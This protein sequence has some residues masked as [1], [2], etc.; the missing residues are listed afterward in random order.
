[1]SGLF[2]ASFFNGGSDWLLLAVLLPVFYMISC[3]LKAEK[4]DMLIISVSF[5]VAVSASMIKEKLVYDRIMAYSG[6]ECNFSGEI[7]S[8]D[9]YNNE[10]VLYIIEGEINGAQKARLSF[11]SQDLNA[12]QGD[13]I[14]I[15]NAKLEPLSVTYLFNEEE[16]YKSR[17]IFL[18]IGRYESIELETRRCRVFFRAIEDYRNKIVNEFCLRIGQQNGNILSGMVFGEDGGIDDGQKALLYRCG[19][20]HILAVS[21]LHVS[22]IVALLMFILEKLRLNRYFSFAVINFFMILMIIMVRYPVSAIRAVLMLDIMY[23]ARLLRRQNDSLNSLSIAVLLICLSNPYVITD[24]GFL[25]SVSG[26]FGIAVFGPYMAEKINGDDIKSKFLKTL[27]VMICTSLA[28]TPFSIL[29]FDETSAIAPL[30]NMVIAPLC[31]VS[32]VCGVIHTLTAGLISPLSLA[33]VLT[34]AVV[35]IT[36]KLGRAEL[37]HFSCG[38]SKLF[39]IAMLCAVFVGAVQLFLKRRKYTAVAIVSAV[40]VFA[41]SSSLLSLT[42]HFKFRIAVLGSGTNTAI[43][44]TYKGRTDIIDLSGHYASP[45]YVSKYLTSNGIS[46]V[47]SLIL[48]SDIQSVYTAY[49]KALELTETKE[50]YAVGATEIFGAQ[51]KITYI[52]QKPLII[53]GENYEARC[54]NGVLNISFKEISVTVATTQNNA[55]S[56][57]NVYYG[58]AGKDSQ[59]DFSGLEIWLDELDGIDYNYDELNNFE[60]VISHGGESKIRRL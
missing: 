48:T 8:A 57:V 46:E 58:N 32:M 1:M 41:F 19:I 26:T 29:F 17:N 42:E 15:E 3:F 5:A 18:S 39:V 28:V 44:V 11:F 10:K 2:F 52:G 56:D 43:A 12:R 59:P 50:I 37:T 9:Y 45:Q 7:K 51:D 47:D 35:W 53:A 27:T 14:S 49:G 36:D 38:S 30:S 31:V 22:I 60:I 34:D 54:E 25:L 55:D 20:G 13:L 23:S 33:E 40:S 21:G 6:K 16:Y 4:K 24:R